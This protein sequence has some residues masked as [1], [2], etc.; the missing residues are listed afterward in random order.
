MQIYLTA[1]PEDL[2]AA[3][4]YP[5]QVAHLAYT[6][7]KDLH[8]MRHNLLINT[9]GGLLSLSAPD[10]PVIGQGDLLRRQLLRECGIRGFRGVCAELPVREDT[11]AFLR[12]LQQSLA[13]EQK[14][15]FLPS[16][17][18]RSVPGAVAV[19]CTALSGGSF[20]EYM[21]DAIR[22]FGSVALDVQRLI[23][24]FPLPSPSGE[25][26]PL[27]Q[28]ELSRILSDRSPATFYSSELCARYF[29]YTEN[30]HSHFLIFDDEDTI[31]QKLNYGKKH[32]LTAAFLLY[33]EVSDLL[34]GIF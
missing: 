26:R 8:L 33:P 22:T 5:C 10:C 14:L 17:A 34:P 20:R 31:R 7:G 18:A 1:A 12:R 24:D 11:I 2:R 3:Q 29:T 6:I 13:R 27:K 19:V 30:G 32:H 4:K 9:R 21:E 25:G 23:M 15:L 16:D 28:E